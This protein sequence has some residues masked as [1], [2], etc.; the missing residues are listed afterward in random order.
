LSA[1]A[2]FRDGGFFQKTVRFSTPSDSQNRALFRSDFRPLASTV[3]PEV[4]IGAKKRKGGAE[5][6]AYCFDIPNKNGST[7]K[8]GGK[9]GK[10]LR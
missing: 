8:I 7:S 9:G 1:F 2:D 4:K 3:L 10:R 5:A 6:A